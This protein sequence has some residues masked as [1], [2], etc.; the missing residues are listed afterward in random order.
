MDR[1]I[2]LLLFTIKIMFKVKLTIKK[3]WSL[4]LKVVHNIQVIKIYGQVHRA[5]NTVSVSALDGNAQPLKQ[6]FR[7]TSPSSH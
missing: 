5:Q 6:K 2:Y 7:C 4:Q 3:N 1:L